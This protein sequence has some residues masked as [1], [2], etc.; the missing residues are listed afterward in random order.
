MLNQEEQKALTRQVS[1]CFQLAERFFNTPF[2]LPKVLH[3]QRGKIAGTAHLTLWVLKFNP[4]L[5][6]E[7]RA[8]F[9]A[10][11]VPHEVAHLLAFHL[12]GNVPPH[13][14]HWQSLMT[15][16]FN[17]PPS[18]THSY[19]VSSLTGKTYTYQCICSEHALTIRRHNKAQKGATYLC[20]LCRSALTPLGY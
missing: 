16:V 6:R 9:L 10:H 19:D 18:R 8:H 17:L 13:G 14:K 2:P 5:F 7:N 15:E 12:Y 11:V 3:N 20:K 4:V 1:S